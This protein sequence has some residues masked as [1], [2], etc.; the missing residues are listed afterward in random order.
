M[1]LNYLTWIGLVLLYSQVLGRK[2]TLTI[3]CHS[4]NQQILTNVNQVGLWLRDTYP[5]FL[6]ANIPEKKKIENGLHK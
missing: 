6:S 2:I 3:K 5:S 1:I 4:K